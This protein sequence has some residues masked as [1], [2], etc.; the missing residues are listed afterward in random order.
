MPRVYLFTIG[1]SFL[2]GLVAALLLTVGEVRLLSII[3]VFIFLI[4][5]V[6]E[7]TGFLEDTVSRKTRRQLGMLGLIILFLLFVFV[8]LEVIR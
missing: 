2:A 7:K 6:N 8:L 4:V 1:L 3:L 5:L